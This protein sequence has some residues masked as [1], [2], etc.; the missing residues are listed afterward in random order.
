[1]FKHIPCPEDVC[2]GGR[3]EE[4]GRAVDL[5]YQDST[6]CNLVVVSSIFAALQQITGYMVIKHENAVHKTTITLLIIAFM[7]IF[8]LV[9]QGEGHENFNVLTLLAIVLLCSVQRSLFVT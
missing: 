1:M 2:E 8:F 4:L 5:L 7:W 6:L 3:L 9:Y